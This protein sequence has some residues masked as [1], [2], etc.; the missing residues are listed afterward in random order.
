MALASGLGLRPV[1]CRTSATSQ[2]GRDVAPIRQG[3]FA[4][5]RPSGW[6]RGWDSHP[7]AWLLNSA[8]CRPI[9]PARV[10]RSP[11]LPGNVSG[12]C[13]VP[14]RGVSRRL[15]RLY[16]GA[17]LAHGRVWWC[18][19]AFKRAGRWSRRTPVRPEGI[20]PSPRWLKP[21]RSVARCQGALGERR[22][23][24]SAL[25]AGHR[26][27]SM[28]ACGGTSKAS[29]LLLLD[30]CRTHA[31]GF[32]SEP[33]SRLAQ[34]VRQGCEFLGHSIERQPFGVG[35]LLVVDHLDVG[36]LDGEQEVEAAVAA[37]EPTSPVR[38]RVYVGID[39]AQQPDDAGTLHRQFFVDLAEHG[40]CRLL[41]L[42][43]VTAD[44]GPNTLVRP[45]AAGHQDR[46][47][48][49]G[50]RDDRG[51][52]DRPSVIGSS[53]RLRRYGC[54]HEDRGG[55]WRCC[56]VALWLELP[57]CLDRVD[58]HVRLS[59]PASLIRLEVEFLHEP[60]N[61]RSGDPKLG[62]DGADRL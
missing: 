60:V 36:R 53:W 11:G 43:D 13:Q 44:P 62:T 3:P 48:V 42:V 22:R 61:R 17:A 24:R 54:W 47:F 41:A 19:T 10:R 8:G 21:V 32:T 57:R 51:D 37:A 1:P 56:V 31:Y 4:R 29:R 7:R 33:E 6:R 59:V 20:R 55:Y 26:S 49:A 27:H 38:G 5:P 52:H 2:P 40:C 30:R 28:S 35:Q 25:T 46:L 14:C 50:V 34:L 9:R 12:A 18:G 39:C 15:T 23:S 45:N 58:V 16:L